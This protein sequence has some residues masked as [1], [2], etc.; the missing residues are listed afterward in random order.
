[1]YSLTL[2]SPPAKQ[3]QP[4][5]RPLQIGPKVSIQPKPLIAAVPLARA[6]A[7]LQ[8]KTIIIQ[9]VQTTVLPIVKPAPISIQPAPP[10]GQFS[11]LHHFGTLHTLAHDD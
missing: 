9:P 2:P 3:A 10:T 1:M 6:A 7:P 4:I 8:A 5:K 11:Q